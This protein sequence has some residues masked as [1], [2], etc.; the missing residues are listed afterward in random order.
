MKPVAEPGRPPW[1]NKELNATLQRVLNKSEKNSDTLCVES[2]TSS[3]RGGSKTNTKI[4]CSVPQEI[5][6]RHKDVFTDSNIC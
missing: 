3:L 5:S 6:L 2:I 1:H 4:G